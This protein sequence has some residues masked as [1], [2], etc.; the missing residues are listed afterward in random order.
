M[1][2]YAAMLVEERKFEVIEI[3]FLI[4]GHTHASIDQY[5]SILAKRIMDKDFIGSP[6]SLAAL[7]ANTDE[8]QSLSGTPSE[9][10][11]AQKASGSSRPFLVKKL[12]ALF[13]L[14]TIMAPLI[15]N[16]IKYY[17]IPHYFRFELFNNVPAMQYAI[18]STQ[19]TL[20]PLRPDISG[21]EGVFFFFAR[22][23]FM[24]TCFSLSI[25]GRFCHEL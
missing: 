24:H 23:M 22:T 19:K 10:H 9:E 7:L 6:L 25:V 12:S 15:N 1:F 8:T 17:P 5:F 18:Y 3:F 13:N 20:L 21:G 16:A 4:V 2:T 14:K 11:R